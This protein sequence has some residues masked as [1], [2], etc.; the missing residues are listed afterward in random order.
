MSLDRRRVVSAAAA[1]TVARCGLRQPEG[2]RCAAGVGRLLMGDGETRVG[3]RRRYPAERAGA[4]GGL[5]DLSDAPSSAQRYR[6][7]TR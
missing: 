2:C 4:V 1:A 6:S 3:E 7:P 5:S